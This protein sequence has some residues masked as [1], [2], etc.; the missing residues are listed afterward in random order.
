MTKKE[1]SKT[2]APSMFDDLISDLREDFDAESTQASP[3]QFSQPKQGK[4]VRMGRK[5]P[6]W[7]YVAIFGTACIVALFAVF[8]LVTSRKEASIAQQNS[9]GVITAVSTDNLLLS[10]TFP[11][12]AAPTEIPL[13]ATPTAESLPNTTD[14]VAP[15][16]TAWPDPPTPTPIPIPE[17]E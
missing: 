1:L 14:P 2:T 15:E 7:S 5:L 16:P 17:T 12:P 3:E 4:E 9:D 13:P 11:P 6:Q 8:F 10:A